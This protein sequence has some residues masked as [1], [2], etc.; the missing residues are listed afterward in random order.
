MDSSK[1]TASEVRTAISAL[2][3]E[4]TQDALA[5]ISITCREFFLEHLSKCAALADKDG[6]SLKFIGAMIRCLSPKAV[7]Q[8]KALYPGVSIEAVARIAASTPNK[9]L[10]AVEAASGAA[11]VRHNEAKSFLDSSFSDKASSPMLPATELASTDKPP[12]T[13]KESGSAENP[14]C[15]VHVYGASYALCFN[16]GKRDGQQGVMVDAAAQAGPKSYD[17]QNAIH[18]WL[19]INE[20]LAV[21]AVLRRWRCSIELTNHGAQND[22]SFSLEFQDR[23]FF[24]KVVAKKAP[25]HPARA[26]KILPKDAS[27][28]AIL[29][30][31]QIGKNFPTIPLNE[32]LATARAAHS[33]C[34]AKVA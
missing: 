29:F 31:S 15:S 3:F 11:G 24:A 10:S 6:K 13:E 32:L 33:S 7:A 18:L 30:L 19:D 26:V 28:V 17:W 4:I 8:I 23:H 34:D 25:S 21:L 16:A 9:L 20:V 27:A 1:A 12:R 5:A 14:Y 22:K 2:G